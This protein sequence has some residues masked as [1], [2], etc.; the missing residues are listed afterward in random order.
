MK[1]VIKLEW[2]IFRKT[3]SIQGF[4][5]VIT[6]AIICAGILFGTKFLLFKIGHYSML[7]LVI[8]TGFAT[9]LIEL[10]YSK[11][12]EERL[13]KIRVFFDSIDYHEAK[14]YCI[15]RNYLI[16]IIGYVYLLIPRSVQDVSYFSIYVFCMQAVI[17]FFSIVKKNCSTKTSYEIDMFFKTLLFVLVFAIGRGWV[18]IDV[19]GKISIPVSGCILFISFIMIFMNVKYT[20]QLE[21][22]SD[23]YASVSS[24]RIPFIQKDRFLLFFVR[25]HVYMEIIVLILACNLT[26]T[27]YFETF[28]AQIST[29]TITFLSAYSAMFM[30]IY[31]E[32]SKKLCLFYQP[33]NVKQLRIESM[34]SILKFSPFIL[35]IVVIPLCLIMNWKAVLLGYILSIPIFVI[36]VLALKMSLEKQFDNEKTVKIR[37]MLKLGMYNVIL[38]GISSWLL[39]RIL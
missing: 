1:R 39:G 10:V 4:F 17:L 34:K 26:I 22:T 37:D 20:Q 27:Q 21:H 38:E 5:N 8:F 13:T 2:Q 9:L 24:I 33:G 15:C 29:M 18:T 6:F 35:A 30:E 14:K 19:I 3:F 23:S 16:F 36:A 12:W 11:K 31:F 25:K 7:A 28:T 32:E